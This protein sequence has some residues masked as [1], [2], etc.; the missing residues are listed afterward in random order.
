MDEQHGASA[1]ELA[2]TSVKM[3][4]AQLTSQW[5]RAR[6]VKPQARC[7]GELQGGDGVLLDDDGGDAQRLDLGEDLFDLLDDDRGETLIG[8]IEEQEL[9]VAGEGAGDG[10]HLL[11]AAREGDAF[12][13]AA[14]G[15]EARMVT[16]EG[17]AYFDV[18]HD[19][20][21]PFT[22]RTATAEIR[23][24]GTAFS[25][26]TIADGGVAV[27]VTHGIMA[28]GARASAAVPV[29][30]NAGDR[31]TLADGAVSVSRGVVTS[32]DVAWTEGALR[33]RDASLAEVRADLLRWYGVDVRVTDSTL[34]RRTITAAFRGEPVAR[35]LET[36]ALT[37]GARVEQRGDTVLLQPRGADAV[38]VR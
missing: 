16:L 14:F 30:L 15:E 20:A 27:A 5:R 10:K 17:A 24:L 32:D 35:V 12:L 33:Y 13:A 23:D 7:S 37:L 4:A 25:V 29:E 34:A 21:R 1:P 38:P 3:Q 9:Q 2:E 6:P 26:K 36:L 22:V 11:F 31:G 19:D 8:F 28:L 18:V